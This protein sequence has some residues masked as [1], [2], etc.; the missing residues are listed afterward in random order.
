MSTYSVADAKSGL[1]RLIDRAL[2]GEEVVIIARSGSYGMP[3][4]VL[5]YGLHLGA[6]LPAHATSTGCV[7]LAAMSTTQLAQWLKGRVLPRLTPRTITQVRA[8][9]QRI[10]QVR[11]DDS[12]WKP[13]TPRKTLTNTSCVRSAASA[14]S[15]TVRAR[16]E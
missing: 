16:S 14:R 5:A 12:P 8:L 9:R 13:P 3:T 11:K 6:R 15:C 4:R 10:V 1:P 2:D 7:L